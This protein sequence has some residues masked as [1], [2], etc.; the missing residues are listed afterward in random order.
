MHRV[1]IDLGGTKIEGAVLD[2]Q[3]KVLVRR[4]VPTGQEDG[5]EAILDR[6][7]RLYRDILDEA[8]NPFHTLGVG[9]PGALELQTGVLKNSNTQCLKGR[10]IHHDLEQRFGHALRLEN[11]ANCFALAEATLGAGRGAR[12]VFG[13][14]MGTGCGGGLV[15]DGQVWTG[16]RAIAGEWGHMSIDPKGPECYCGRRGCVETFISGGG[17]E[18]Q[19]KEQQGSARRLAD[20]VSGYREGEP[21]ARRFMEAFFEN[22]GRAMGNLVNMLD[23]DVIVL[24]GGVSNIDEVYREGLVAVQRHVFGGGEDT[25]VLRHQLG[26]S[27]G[28]IGAAM[29]GIP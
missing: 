29:L 28:V 19:W 8:G 21:A 7:A 18:R 2:E 9:T 20:I 26:D 17:L 5:Y 14:I 13:V 4:R 15:I 11:D 12:M 24:G 25:P 3:G 22:F 1:G 6:M 10:P 16:H 23:P 27:A